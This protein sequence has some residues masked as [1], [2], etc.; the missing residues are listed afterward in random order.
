MRVVYMAA[1]RAH[2]RIAGTK[3]ARYVRCE[4]HAC[5]DTRT[6]LRWLRGVK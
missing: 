6:W 4:C 5:T 1:L 3:Q 2:S